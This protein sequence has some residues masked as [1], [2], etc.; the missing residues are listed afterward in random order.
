[1][2]LRPCLRS[3]WIDAEP[4][5]RRFLLSEPNIIGNMLDSFEMA[6]ASST[7][8]FILRATSSALMRHTKRSKSVTEAMFS[9]ELF[10]L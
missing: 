5:A 3:T 9:G 2:I 4:R 7:A 6:N 8:I 10:T 1:M